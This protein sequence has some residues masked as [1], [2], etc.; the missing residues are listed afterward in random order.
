[1]SIKMKIFSILSAIAL[2][3]GIVVFGVYAL[4]QVSVNVGGSVNFKAENVYAR[5]T[6]S[7]ANAQ[8]NPS[9]F[10]VTYSGNGTIGDDTIWDTLNLLFNDSATPIVI[11][12]AVENLSLENG[13]TLNLTDSLASETYENFGK[14]IQRD[15]VDYT[16]GN[17][18]ELAPRNNGTNTTTFKI[19]LSVLN[20]GIPLSNAKF[21]YIL[22]LFNA[23]AT[24]AVEI[25][26]VEINDL[27]PDSTSS[28]NGEKSLYSKLDL[29][30][31]T[32]ETGETEIIITER[33]LHSNYIKN[34]VSY[35]ALPNNVMVHSTSLYLPQ[36]SSGGGTSTARQLKI[37]VNNDT[38]TPTTVP[39][40][41][42]S[43]EEKQSLLQNDT[44]NQ[45]Y[46]VEMGTIMGV[47]QSEYIRWRYF[48]NG[49]TPYVYNSSTPPT[50]SGYFILETD[51]SSAVGRDGESNMINMVYSNEFQYSQAPYTHRE[52]GWNNIYAND[53]ATSVIRQYIN[54]NTVQQ[55]FISSSYIASPFGRSANMFTDFNIDAENDIIYQDIMARSLQDLYSGAGYSGTMAS[56]SFPDVPFP[57]FSDTAT[58]VY[59]KNDV[60]KFWL[61]SFEEV[62]KLIG[63]GNEDRFW[64]ESEEVIYCWLRSP[65]EAAYPGAGVLGVRLQGNMGQAVI[66][67]Y[68]WA[69]PAFQFSV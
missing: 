7:I 68:A 54:G 18:V 26:N 51:V 35:N 63:S 30:S 46:Y 15:S 41:A 25:T 21:T 22:N 24:P 69:R 57:T 48:S 2:V 56:P 28:F 64:L 47:T 55:G 66:Y 29:S 13:L 43:F 11:T 59:E 65:Y 34:I 33:S 42:V 61:L 32:F 60:D 12:I 39:G 19:T 6:G 4:S 37:Y 50:S 9:A 38:G 3:A 16:S 67:N 14:T 52:N 17:E 23:E 49:S 31:I 27:T 20:K 53:Y 45:Y 10:D 40:L 8:S 1:M 62:Y 58:I 36:S 44:I 5:V